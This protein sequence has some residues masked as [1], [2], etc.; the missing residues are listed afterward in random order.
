M[1]KPIGHSFGDV[2]FYLERLAQVKGPVLE[3]ATGTGRILIPLLEA[4][5]TVDGFDQS[6][7]MLKI[8]QSNCKDRELATELFEADME[9]FY[10]NQRY[11]A[12]VVATGTFLLIHERE[13]SLQVLR[14]FRAHLRDGGRLIV[15]LLLPTDLTVGKMSTKIW[16][17]E[18]G[19]VITHENKLVEVDMINQFTISHGRYEKWR[20][21]KLI[22]TELERFPLRWYGIEEFRHILEGLGFEDIVISADYS[23]GTYPQKPE[24]MI[25][26]EATYHERW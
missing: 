5:L 4:G 23:Y 7:E 10:S 24:Q 6:S 8:C 16:E 17:C 2:E 9:S 12:I 11:E 20:K 21:G 19:D 1:D 22:E 26:F 25:T 18:N 15:D 13:K 3:P 14:N